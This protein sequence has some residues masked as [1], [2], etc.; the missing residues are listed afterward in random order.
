LAHWRA[1]R[2]QGSFTLDAYDDVGHVGIMRFR[3][4]WPEGKPLDA[5]EIVWH[6]QDDEGAIGRHDSQSENS[7]ESPA[8]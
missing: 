2:D 4:S 3:N 1:I 6:T 5:I 7:V 8:D